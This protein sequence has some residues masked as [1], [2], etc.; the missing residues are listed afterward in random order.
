MPLSFLMSLCT[1]FV[2]KARHYDPTFRR[3]F[4]RRPVSSAAASTNIHSVVKV[5]EILNFLKL[6][7]ICR[8][9]G[10]ELVCD[11]KIDLYRKV[12]FVKNKSSV[13]YA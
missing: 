8:K 12:N 10:Q 9:L 6:S 11:H 7:W 1:T 2:A 3:R 5:F 13:F 4:R